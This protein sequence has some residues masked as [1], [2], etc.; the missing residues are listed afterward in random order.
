M[1]SRISCKPAY[2]TVV[3]EF[4]ATTSPVHGYF[5]FLNL[6]R[7]LYHLSGRDDGLVRDLM[8]RLSRDGV[9]TVPEEMKAKMQTDFTGGWCDDGQTA[10]TIACVWRT[11]RYLCDTHTAVAVKVCGEYRRRTGDGT[12]CV[13]RLHRESL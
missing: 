11:H 12:P 9:Y 3:E 5:D 4:H 13:D 6:E 1:C 7:L 2:T 8:T 10:A